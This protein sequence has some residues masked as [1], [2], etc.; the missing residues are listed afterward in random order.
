[1]FLYGVG[2]APDRILQGISEPGAFTV[3]AAPTINRVY[4]PIPGDFNGDGWCDLLLYGPG[5]T[6]D[7]LMLNNGMGVLSSAPLAPINGVY[8][9]IVGD[10][11]GD[12]ISDVYWYSS[13][14]S[15]LFSGRSTGGFVGSLPRQGPAHTIP[16][17]GDFDGN[18]RT[19]ILW[20]A[21]GTATDTLWNSTPSGFHQ[22]VDISVIGT[23]TALVTDI[24]GDGHDEIVWVRP[25][26]STLT[27][28]YSL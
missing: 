8:T 12:A 1:M 10:F 26:G 7:K 28:K 24:D 21:P 17:A 20:Y 6:V 9:P 19:D 27:W 3:T 2:K 13:T 23:Y 25:S 18:G 11:N 15:Y 16:V 5:H 22:L 14:R 4:V